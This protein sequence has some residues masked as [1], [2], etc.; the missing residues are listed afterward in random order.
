[1][2]EKTASSGIDLPWI[3]VPLAM[4]GGFL[5]WEG[6]SKS[7]P[8]SALHGTI[9]LA[10]GIAVWF[11]QPLGRLGGAIYFALVA[12]GKFYQQTV[13]DFALPEMLVTAGCAS[14]AW[15]LWHWKELPS[16]SPKKP[17][18]SIV[19]L[20]RQGRFMNDKAIARAATAA[21]GTPFSTGDPRGKG[22]LVAGETPLFV[23]RTGDES[24][25]VHNQNQRYFEGEKEIEVQELRLRNALT[26]HSA[27]IAVDLL[28]TDHKK[29]KAQEAYPKIGRLVAELGGHDCLAILCPETGFVGLYDDT[30]EEKLRTPDPLRALQ[31]SEQIPV[32]AVPEGDPRMIAAVEVARKRWP[33]FVA[34]FRARKPGQTF[35]VK[36]PITQGNRTEFIWLQVSEIDDQQIR[37]NI[38]NDPVDL[39]LECGQAVTVGLKDLNDWA[40]SEGE[41]TTGLFTLN[42]IQQVAAENGKTEAGESKPT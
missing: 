9:I 25:L 13:G 34:A 20:L 6:L 26:E 11:Q 39:D 10:V 40:F 38:D 27:W 37:G 33:E 32:I 21:W 41:H 16:S 17:L 23:V 12:A 29:N 4:V 7:V 14:L 18:V 1:M 24:Y 5:L 42:V 28:D 35:A 3:A 30:T 36:A 22:N 15:A 19:L 8:Y 31:D 2:N